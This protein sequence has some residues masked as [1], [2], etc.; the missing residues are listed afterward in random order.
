MKGIS[1]KKSLFFQKIE[2]K[3]IYFSNGKISFNRR[4]NHLIKKK[5]YLIVIF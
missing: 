4:Y 1:I 3:K 2:L 5:L